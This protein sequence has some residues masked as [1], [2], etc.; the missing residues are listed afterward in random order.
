MLRNFHDSVSGWKLATEPRPRPAGRNGTQPL[1]GK[2]HR[3][4]VMPKDDPHYAG[5]VSARAR[6]ESHTDPDHQVPVRPRTPCVQAITRTA[7][8][9]PADDSPD[10]ARLSHADLDD[11]VPV[12]PPNAV[13]ACTFT[14]TATEDPAEGRR[15]R[16]TKA[17]PATIVTN[18]STREP[19]PLKV[20]SQT[21]RRRRLR[22]S[23][24]PAS[25]S[26]GRASRRGPRKKVPYEV[27]R[28]GIY[29]K[30]CVQ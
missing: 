5:D 16:N 7:P 22:S 28:V 9:D 17:R 2:N 26:G 21:S 11:Q 14:R 23:R 27:R 19:T 3:Q 15:D 12:R 24:R 8:E 10:P 29:G 20:G 30:E 18:P 13:R 25:A 4:V 6:H 1:S